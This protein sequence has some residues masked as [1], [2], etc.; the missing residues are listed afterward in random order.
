MNFSELDING[1]IALGAAIVGLITTILQLR[2]NAKVTA[3]AADVAEVKVAIQETKL[4]EQEER[5]KM[6][7]LFDE[8]LGSMRKPKRK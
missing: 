8:A 7:D 3:A 5:K 1:V 2:G 6:A 4:V